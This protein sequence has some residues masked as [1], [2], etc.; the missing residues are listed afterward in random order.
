MK[1]I[2][3]NIFILLFSTCIYAQE[4]ANKDSLV[5]EMTKHTYFNSHEEAISREAFQDSLNTRRYNLQFRQ[6]KDSLETQTHLVSKT[7]TQDNSVSTKQKNT[8]FDPAE[9][10]ISADAFQDSLKTRKY[11][12]MFR[13]IHG[14]D[15]L[16]MRTYLTPKIPD[17]TKLIGTQFPLLTYYDIERKN[18]VIGGNKKNSILIFWSTVCIP[19]IEELHVFNTLA[20]EFGEVNFFAITSENQT[21]VSRFLDKY[22]IKW[23]NLNIITDYQHDEILNIEVNPLNVILDKDR[24]IKDIYVGGG[25][26]REI[27]NNLN[28]LDEE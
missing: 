9:K 22:K 4:I 20:K 23:N 28:L 26:L 6:G 1:K 24:M 25:K 19:C 12:L 21:T 10:E 15:T 2:I 5:L 8:Y 17:M 3:V 16:E 13:P 11:N 7:S 27:I 14:T 18:I